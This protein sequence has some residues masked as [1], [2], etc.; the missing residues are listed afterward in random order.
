M[1][2]AARHPDSITSIERWFHRISA[3]D[4]RHLQD[5]RAIFPAADQVGT[6]LVFNI[7]GN[8]YRSICCVDFA[9]QRLFFRALLTHAEYDRINVRDLCP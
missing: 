3:A 8:N 7:G 9:R 4:C 5:I 2:A 1:V 6:A